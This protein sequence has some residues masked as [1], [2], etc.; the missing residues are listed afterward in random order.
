MPPPAALFLSGPTASGKTVCALALARAL[1]VEIV[2]VDSALVYRDMNIGTAKPDATERA[3]C[4]HHLIDILSPE[5]SY[6]AAKFCADARRLME[7]I[8]ARGRIP[9]LTGGTMLYFKALREGLSELPQANPAL[10]AEIDRRAQLEGWPTL[11]AELARHDP[12]AAARLAPKDAQRIQRA[13][14]I[15]LTTGEP[16][17]K[18]QARCNPQELPCRP[19][20]VA[21]IPSS[22]EALHARITARF[23]KMLAAGLLDEVSALRR[24]YRLTPELPSMRAVGYRQA[25]ACLDGEIDAATLRDTGIAATRQ[26]AKR[27]LTW[28]RQFRENWPDWIEIDCL[29][30]DAAKAV[31]DAMLVRLGEI[32]PD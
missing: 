28:M 11:H 32:A 12:E 17:A 10:R 21:L 14:E 26:L 30:A 23:D 3:V 29:R 1:P 22:R 24:C 4:P 7:E 19:V 25:W 31:R 2:S 9:L 27:Q 15:V 8:T 6:S 18:A 13:L 5:E 16:L 20:T